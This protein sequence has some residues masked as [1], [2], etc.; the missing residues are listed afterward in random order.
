LL[1]SP[2]AWRLALWDL[3]RAMADVAQLGACDEILK[4]VVQIRVLCLLRV[5]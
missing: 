2:R 5:V 4:R 1:S 3:V